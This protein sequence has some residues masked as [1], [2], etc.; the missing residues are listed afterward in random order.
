MKMFRSILIA[1]FC[2]VMTSGCSTSMRAKWHGLQ[3]TQVL[4]KE[5]YR[6]KALEF[7]SNDQLQESLL[8]LRVAAALDPKDAQ[9]SQMIK[10]LEQKIN[11]MADHHF[12]EGLSEYREGKFTNA[13]RQFLITLRIE[14][15][16]KGAK[17][18]LKTALHYAGHEQYTVQRGDSFVRI[19]THVYNDPTKA[20][21]IAYFND[22]P[23][24]KPLLIGTVLVLPELKA[25]QLLPRKE[26]EALIEKA[27][28]DIASKHYGK[29]LRN[30][31]RIRLISPEHAKITE[32]S[33][34]A[35]YGKAMA[36]LN[37]QKYLSALEH[38]KQ[39]SPG[40]KGRDSAIGAV[41]QKIRAQANDEKIRVAKELF[42]KDDYNGVINICEE[43]ISQDTAPS[44]RTVATDLYNAAHY[45][46]G[47]QLIEQGKEAQALDALSV[48][49]NDY[50]D[51]AQLRTQ[52]R[53]K[54]NAT[55]EDLYRRG[56]KHFL[57][58]ELEQAI[59]DWRKTLAL[60]PN[61][62]K[63][64]QDIDNAIKL[65]EKWRGIPTDKKGQ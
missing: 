2:V 26:V 18:Y 54:L 59:A 48:L 57:N 13:R 3:D 25:N 5:T 15:N 53:A 31:E 46:L 52:A 30:L 43:M 41:R 61:H 17:Y 19:A 47:K 38:L 49:N 20:Y 33:D 35:H 63:A 37:E 7:E 58:E 34:Q 51:T 23:S 16:H 12:Q 6:Q 60:N 4:S 55:A 10:K 39:V 32:L 44:V 50:H 14:P 40:Y 22:H 42:G 62:P 24:E 29:V 65:L 64:R 1:L 36:L 11:E 9:L 21:T 45:A 27:Q 56:V 28:K 8:S